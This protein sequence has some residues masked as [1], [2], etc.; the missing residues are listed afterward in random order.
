MERKKWLFVLL[1]I[2]MAASLACNLNLGGPEPPASPIPV[3]TEEV[4]K[5]KQSL[6]QVYTE[7]VAG[8]EVTIEI[9]ESQMTS[10]AAF[11]LQG[12]ESMDIRD[13]QVFLRDGQIQFFATV[14]QQNWE[15]VLKLVLT[16]DVDTAGNPEFSFVSAKIGPLD[17]PDSILEDIELYVDR[18]FASQID[19]RASDIRIDSITIEDGIM[20]I[21]GQKE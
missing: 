18:A 15:A 2:L 20:K 19:Q 21:T 4:E 6:E 12:Q 5:L 14:T 9:T 13:P 8:S 17:V 16:L 11:E 10:M 1:S 7:G 3:S